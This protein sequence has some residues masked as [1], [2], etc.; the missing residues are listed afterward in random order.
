MIQAENIFLR[1]LEPSDIDYLYLLENNP[2]NWKVSNTLVPFSRDI[3]IQYIQSAQDIFL[4]KQIRF[5]ICDK[6]DKMHV[7]AVDLFDY[8][9]INHRVGVGIIIE[10]KYRG[11]GFAQEALR[12][13]IN[14]CFDVL[15]VHNIYCNINTS[16]KVSI[17]LF[18]KLNFE[19]IGVKND[20]VRVNGG[21][22]DEAMYQLIH[23]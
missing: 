3:L 9:P 8:D 1:T 6:V 20:W 18:E 10:E 4:V 7:G 13:V 23:L 19:R 15:L 2:A 5:V 22:E 11:R 12:E 16:N 14:Y 17:N 21:W